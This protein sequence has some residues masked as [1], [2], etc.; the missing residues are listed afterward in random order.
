MAGDLQ[1]LREQISEVDE[2][3]IKLLASR[4][5]LITQIGEVKKGMDLPVDNP[6]IEKSNLALY[7]QKAEAVGLSA[8]LIQNIFEEVFWDARR[9]QKELREG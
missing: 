2:K 4:N 7:T 8:D 3:L 9:V 5:E 1:S 6:E